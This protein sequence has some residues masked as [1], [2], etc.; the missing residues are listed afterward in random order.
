MPAQPISQAHILVGG[1]G[2]R[3]GATDLPKT[4]LPLSPAG[5]PVLGFVLEMLLKHGIKK[6]II[7]LP[8]KRT[9]PAWP[10]LISDY[11]TAEYGP[12]FRELK[13]L[14][15]KDSIKDSIIDAKKLYDDN[16]FLL[17]GDILTNLNLKNLELAHVENDHLF[18][19]AV[20]LVSGDEAKHHGLVVQDNK[21]AQFLPKNTHHEK[22]GWADT[23]VYIL[24]K[25][26][27]RILQSKTLYH[28][29]IDQVFKKK[30]AGI[31]KHKGYYFDINTP[32]KYDSARQFLAQK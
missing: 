5:Q 17:A 30:Q 32:E 15:A 22:K 21:G 28:S 24:N 9:H 1:R 8:T 4:L 10:K 11:V 26:F 3:I 27:I 7:T 6:L 29:A 13:Y 20:T 25:D 19:L 23:A 2:T 14:E 18:S 16:F 31:Y 12:K